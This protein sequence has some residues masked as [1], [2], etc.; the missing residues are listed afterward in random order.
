MEKAT[1]IKQRLEEFGEL[2]IQALQSEIERQGL[3]DTGSLARSLESE[4]KVGEQ[5]TSLS[6]T[7]AAYIVSL[8]RGAKPLKRETTGKFVDDIKAWA[9]RKLEM[10]PKESLGFAIAYMKRRSGQDPEGGWQTTDRAGNYLVPNRF[11]EGGL[12]EKSLTDAA[13]DELFS[14]ITKL[15]GEEMKDKIRTILK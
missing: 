13:L 9:E 7:G 11:N 1:T 6:I 15:A 4:V 10:D 12:I 2:G 3:T 5:A 14:D 8:D